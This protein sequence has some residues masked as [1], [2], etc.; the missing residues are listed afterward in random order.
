MEGECI[1][2][3]PVVKPENIYHQI[4]SQQPKDSNSKTLTPFV[5]SMEQHKAIANN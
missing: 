4:K 5:K 2:H 1:G 3:V